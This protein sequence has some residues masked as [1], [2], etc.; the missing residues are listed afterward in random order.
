M[1]LTGNLFQLYLGA[2]QKNL[3]ILNV[4]IPTQGRK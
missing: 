3:F 4:Q 2:A 1:C